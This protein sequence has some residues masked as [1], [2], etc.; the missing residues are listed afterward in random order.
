VTS[1]SVNTANGVSG[2]VATAATTPVITL[3]L[4][5]ITPTT[6]VVAS[7]ANAT[8]TATGSLRTAGGAGISGDLWAT[9]IFATG[10]V[11]AAASDSRLKKD[12]TIIGGALAKVQ[13]LTGY[14]FNWD[15]SI[16]REAGFEFSAVRQVGLIAQDVQSVLPE[17]V[18][19]APA[20]DEY[21]TV[22]YERIVALLV[23]AVKDLAREIEVLK[24]R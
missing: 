17:A 8:S 3:I 2:S 11:T 15:Q 16:C 21:L 14:T 20:N 7:A 24:G 22:R 23:E 5:A 1:V 10:D 9:N 19:P 4:G 13:A 12:L 6:V 18:S